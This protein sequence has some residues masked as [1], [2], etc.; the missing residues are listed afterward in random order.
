MA[1]DCLCE[2]QLSQ[3]STTSSWI[4]HLEQLISKAEMSLTGG[5]PGR[6]VFIFTMGIH[7]PFSSCLLL[8]LPPKPWH[9]PIRP[10]ICTLLK[11]LEQPGISSLRTFGICTWIQKFPV[12]SHMS[13]VLGLS[14]L[15]QLGGITA[16]ISL[17]EA[18]IPPTPAAQGGRRSLCSTPGKESD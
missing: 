13:R 5:N 9:Q 2:G 16:H 1:A 12:D 4:S 6:R 17:E 18:L 11:S 14:A 10:W 8:E 3:L 7:A 15:T